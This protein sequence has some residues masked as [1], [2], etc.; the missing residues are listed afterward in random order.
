MIHNMEESMAMGIKKEIFDWEKTLTKLKS[1]VKDDQRF[2]RDA[3]ILTLLINTTDTPEEAIGVLEI[4]KKAILQKY[5][6]DEWMD[7][8]E[9]LLSPAI[10]IAW[11]TKKEIDEVRQINKRDYIQI[12]DAH[13]RWNFC[14]YVWIYKRNNININLYMDLQKCQ[15]KK[16]S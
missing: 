10:I 8:K 9:F 11:G 12:E 2:Y 1:M 16:M 5:V 3:I 14:L 4:Q 7:W 15:K 13:S 6:E